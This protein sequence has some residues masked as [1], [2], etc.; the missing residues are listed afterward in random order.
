VHDQQSDPPTGD[1]YGLSREMLIA[2]SE[3]TFLLSDA[4]FVHTR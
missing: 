3:I 1:C 4:S 2:W